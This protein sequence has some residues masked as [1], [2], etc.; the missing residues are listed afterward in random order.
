MGS[1]KAFLRL[2][3]L[4]L[5]E[6]LIATAKQ[7]SS[8]VAL[9]G[10]KERLRP[11]G[12]VIEDE[13]PGQ[14]PLAGIHAALSSTSAQ[15]L[16]LFLA[17]D[18]PGISAELLK[19][20]LTISAESAKTVTVPYAFG[21]S[22]PLCAVYRKEFAAVAEAALKAGHNKIDALYSMVSI[23]KIEESELSQLG[24]P[25]SIFDNVNTPE[26]WDRMQRR[27]GATHG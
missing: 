5:L 9:V 3:R 12:W 8:T 18:I 13:F 11:Y 20:L 7:V 2:G 27:L 24:F 23:R 19:Y 6:H 1:D 15:D 4:T 25:P 17:V 22:Q 26:D 21:F 16:N 14:G 10:D